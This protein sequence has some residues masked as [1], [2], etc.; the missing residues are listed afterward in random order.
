VRRL[1]VVA[2]AAVTI[3]LA[4]FACGGDASFD[5]RY[6]RAYAPPQTVSVFGVFKDG[7]MSPE[8]WD[9]LGERL[10][11]PLGGRPC[12]IAVGPRLQ[13]EAPSLVA[14]LDDT[15]RASGVTDDVL[16]QFAPMAKSDILLLFTISGH[17]PQ[18]ADAGAGA[19]SRAQPSSNRFASGQRSRRGMGAPSTASRRA[20]RSVFEVSASLYSVKTKES[21]GLIGM[22]YEGQSVDDAFRKFT[23]KLAAELPSARCVG[24]DFAVQV[25]EEKLK[26][27]AE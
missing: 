26:N 21:V 8:A 15:T 7:R 24:W 22:T 25:D 2:L 14:A 9:T 6:A 11:L 27:L 10:S 19:A 18:I 12:E 5:V 4:L 3:T 20:E 16:A 13:Q 1:G 23:E 17:P